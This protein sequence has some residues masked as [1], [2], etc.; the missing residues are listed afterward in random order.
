MRIIFDKIEFVNFKCFRNETFKFNKNITSIYGNNGSGKTTIVDGICYVLFGKDSLFRTQFGLKTKENN[1]EIRDIPHSVE[2]TITVDDK[3]HQLKR[4]ISESTSK[5]GVTGTVS[6]RNNYGFYIDG[7]VTTAGDF[8][9]FIDSLISEELFK[10]ITSPTYFTHLEWKTQ[11]SM[12][13]DMVGEIDTKEITGDDERM[14]ALS[15]V[16]KSSGL[17]EIL[18]HISYKKK[19]IMAQ[20]GNVPVRLG[21]LNKVLPEKKDW[22]ALEKSGKELSR[23]VSDIS[24]KIVEAKNG[25]ADTIRK[26]SIRSKIEFAQKRI[27]NMSISARNEAQ[28]EADKSNSERKK[29]SYE[30]IEKESKLKSSIFDLKNFNEQIE[31]SKE[32]IKSFDAEKKKGSEQWSEMKS[33]VFEFDETTQV[34]PTCGQTLPYNE[35]EERRSMLE[36]KFNETQAEDK[37]R[38]MEN[39]SVISDEELKLT[40]SISEYKKAVKPLQEEIDG[41]KESIEILKG[42]EERLKEEYKK[43]RTYQE[44]LSTK[45][46]F[47][48]TL[49]EIENL[50]KELEETSSADGKVIDLLNQQ[51]DETNEELMKIMSQLSDK[52]SYEKVS[53]QIESAKADKKIFQ[54]QLDEIEQKEDIAKEYEQKCC[55][56]LENKVNDMFTYVKFKMFKTRLNGNSEPYCECS[57]DGIPFTDLNS[58][59]RINAGIDICNTMAKFYNLYAPIIVDNAESVISPIESDMQTVR[60][61]AV[62]TDEIK[63]K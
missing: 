35:I 39:A 55:S 54:K 60:L 26:E 17:E 15:K 32:R 57:Y 8:K 25:G 36:A 14:I 49:D 21:E 6:I 51:L 19:E 20:L 58:A 28:E 1:E 43:P 61:Y 12:L 40:N 53:A 56:I 4:T 24:D 5:D 2:L 31:K 46:E 38:L 18:K 16:V 47:K 42:K 59:A 33:R 41:L 37:K 30:L 10:T 62:L 23:K 48:E 44:I 63:I 3:E 34:C 45:K 50:K 7:D 22:D 52:T 27:D 29:L 9:K 13:Q 11:R